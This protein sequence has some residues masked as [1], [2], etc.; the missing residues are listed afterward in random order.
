MTAETQPAAPVTAPPIDI[1]VG[2][3][4]LRAAL[5]AVLPHVCADDEIPALHRVRLQ[6][7]DAGMVLACALDRFTAAAAKIVVHDVVDLPE[8]AA[9]DIEPRS[10]REVLAVLTPPRD[11]E[12]RSQWNTEAFHLVVSETEV[13]FT[14]EGALLDGR[15]LTV[16]RIPSDDPTF[17]GFPDVPRLIGRH[18]DYAPLPEVRQGLAPQLLTRWV[19][20]A[21]VYESSIPL[22]VTPRHRPGHGLCG[23]TVRAGDNQAAGVLMPARVEVDVMAEADFEWASLLARAAGT[24]IADLSADA[25]TTGAHL[26][27]SPDDQDGDD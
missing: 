22:E 18:M 13:T 15:S 27:T 6:I 8:L 2:R 26:Y 9:I 17:G 25:S 16:P 21:A 14:E 23:W 20:T 10:A 12:T 3:A 11:K 24:T 19:K 7:V 1:Y 4:S 5:A